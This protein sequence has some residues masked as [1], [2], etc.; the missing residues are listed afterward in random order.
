MPSPESKPNVGSGVVRQIAF[1]E[2]TRMDQVTEG[3]SSTFYKNIKTKK[4]CQVTSDKNGCFLARLKP[5]KYSMMVKEEGQW[6]ANSFGPN[7]EIFE[8][9]VK[10]NEVTEVEFRINHKAAF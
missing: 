6:Y 4:I 10:A 5:G 9:E 8:I 1:F 2:P 7:G 3:K